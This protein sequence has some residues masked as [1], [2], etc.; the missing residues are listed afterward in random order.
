MGTS[1]AGCDGWTQPSPIK[2][3]IELTGR[4]PTS[5]RQRFANQ[6]LAL[7]IRAASHQESRGEA[8]L[9]VLEATA[10]SPPVELARPHITVKLTADRLLLPAETRRVLLQ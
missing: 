6:R 7:Q 1:S 8:N 10:V 9:R 5:S 3:T 2:L 4:S